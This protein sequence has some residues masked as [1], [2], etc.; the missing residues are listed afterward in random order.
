MGRSDSRRFLIMSFKYRNTSLA[1]IGLAVAAAG[2][3]WYQNKP[4]ATAVAGANPS[5]PAASSSAP[6]AP[7]G[8]AKPVAPG[9][10][11]GAPAGPPMA[12]GVEVAV[13]QSADLRDDAQAVGSLKSRQNTMIRPEMAGRVVALG[14]SDGSSVRAGQMLVQLDDSL[15]RAEIAQSLAQVSI[16]QAN[17]KLAAFFK[18]FIG[19]FYLADEGV[20]VFDKRLHDLAQ[21]G[22]WGFFKNLQNLLGNVLACYI[23]HL[24]LQTVVSK[25]MRW[26]L[27]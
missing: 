10:P 8:A 1:V 3:W 27:L 4:A 7:A 22:V 2:G 19:G 12:M 20:Q 24:K 18:L 9:A 17:H 25:I 15:Q 5:A 6:A 21:A 11:G 26:G 16:A 13:V 23:G 14:F